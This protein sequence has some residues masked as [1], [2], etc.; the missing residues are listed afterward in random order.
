MYGF[1]FDERPEPRS[2]W[3]EDKIAKIRPEY[4]KHQFRSEHKSICQALRKIKWETSDRASK[5]TMPSKQL[6]YDRLHNHLLRKQDVPAWVAEAVRLLYDHETFPDYMVM[7]LRYNN[8]Q[9]NLINIPGLSEAARKCGVPIKIEDD[10]GIFTISETQLV[11]E[12]ASGRVNLADTAEHPRRPH[13]RREPP[14]LSYTDFT[15]IR[16]PE[17]NLSPTLF[18]RLANANDPAQASIL[19]KD[20]PQDDDGS[21]GDVTPLPVR[22]ARVRAYARVLEREARGTK[23]EAPEDD[24][25]IMSEDEIFARLRRRR[26]LADSSSPEQPENPARVPG[27][28]QGIRRE[29]PDIDIKAA[30]LAALSREPSAWRVKEESPESALRAAQARIDREPSIGGYRPARA[31]GAGGSAT[32]TASQS[33][34]NWGSFRSTNIFP[35]LSQPTAPRNSA[36][37]VVHRNKFPTPRPSRTGNASSSTRNVDSQPESAR[38]SSLPSPF[39]YSQFPPRRTL[40]SGSE[41]SSSA[42]K[43]KEEPTDDYDSIPYGFTGFHF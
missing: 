22:R 4:L 33:S 11:K 37:K 3:I 43:I 15:L 20:E 31:H 13:S 23:R 35:E 28:G 29:S 2:A 21:F 39:T 32:N 18:N 7:K 9:P 38:A 19:I 27:L 10:D 14:G 5:P 12:E 26:I 42:P 17:V 8:W 24:G 16:D 34:S 36:S 41:G 6:V 30:P 1:D 40:S 25:D